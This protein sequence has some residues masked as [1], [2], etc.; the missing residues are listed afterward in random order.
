LRVKKLIVAFEPDT[1]L[2]GAAGA[3][4]S[5]RHALD[6]CEELGQAKTLLVQLVGERT[7]GAD[8]RATIAVWHT[9]STERS[10]SEVGFAASTTNVDNDLRPPMIAVN[11]P[12]GA[13]VE[14]VLTIADK[15]VTPD[16]V[17]AFALAIYVTAIYEE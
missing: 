1:Y 6:L 5:Y 3:A 10:P 15:K 12:L 17:Q 7:T 11:G 14:V 4:K 2:S 16:T 9:S 13:R 8:T